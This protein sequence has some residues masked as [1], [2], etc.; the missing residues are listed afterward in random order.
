MF[1][2][3]QFPID[4]YELLAYYL[5]RK[6]PHQINQSTHLNR[7]GNRNTTRTLTRQPHCSASR[8]EHDV[9]HTSFRHSNVLIVR[10]YCGVY[11]KVSDS[12]VNACWGACIHTPCH[13]FLDGA[14]VWMSSGGD[15]RL[16]SCGKFG[17]VDTTWWQTSTSQLHTAITA[18]QV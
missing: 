16:R 9:D 14:R 11:Q 8:N 6:L 17:A 10:C 1:V 13:A 2:T 5:L 3:S 15:W 4:L 18:I 12:R 7:L